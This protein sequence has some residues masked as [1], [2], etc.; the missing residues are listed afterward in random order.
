MTIPK[1]VAEKTII[2]EANNKPVSK[3]YPASLRINGD[4]SPTTSTA[5]VKN[6]PKRVNFPL[7]KKAPE[8]SS[9]GNAVKFMILPVKEA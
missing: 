3:R 5:M 6:V 8:I 1:A 2:G 4:V 7:S 9:I